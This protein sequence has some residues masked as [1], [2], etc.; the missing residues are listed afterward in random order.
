LYGLGINH[1]CVC[2]AHVLNVTLRIVK[3]NHGMALADGFITQ[4]DITES[5]TPN[6]DGSFG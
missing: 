4:G 1:R 2:T 5:I 3:K 6:S